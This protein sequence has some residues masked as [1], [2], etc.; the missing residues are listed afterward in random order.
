MAEKDRFTQRSQ[1]GN[2]RAIP[3]RDDVVSEMQAQTTEVP[4]RRITVADVYR[5]PRGDRYAKHLIV[6]RG[7]T[8]APEAFPDGTIEVDRILPPP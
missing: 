5:A 6:R 3:M 7:E 4:D 8:I 1:R 2:E